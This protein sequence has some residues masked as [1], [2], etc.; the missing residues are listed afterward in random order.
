M[1]NSL[2]DLRDLLIPFIG[3]FVQVSD[4]YG[5]PSDCKGKVLRERVCVNVSGLFMEI[6]SPGLDEI[7]RVSVL[8]NPSVV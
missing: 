2:S 3:K 6:R 1:G 7:R 8:R 4:M 5:P